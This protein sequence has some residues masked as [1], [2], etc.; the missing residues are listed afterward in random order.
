ML[1]ASEEHAVAGKLVPGRSLL[2]MIY[3]W[4]CTND[5]E[6]ATYDLRD[7]IEVVWL[8]DENITT[9]KHTVQNYIFGKVEWPRKSFH[10]RLTLQAE[11][12]KMA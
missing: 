2:H 7:L 6:G 9:F 12:G 11:R 8:G 4:H 3:R 1:R 10:F 5:E